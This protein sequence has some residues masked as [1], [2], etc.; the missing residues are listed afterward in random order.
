M[1]E[2]MEIGHKSVQWIDDPRL[3]DRSFL[4]E[5]PLI[6]EK[7]H[8]ANVDFLMGNAVDKLFEC[9]VPGPFAHFAPYPEYRNSIKRLF[10]RKVLA[11]FDPDFTRETLDNFF[12]GDGEEHEE[13]GAK[14]YEM[15]EELTNLNV[16]LEEIYHKI[17]SCLKP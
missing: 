6:P 12:E 7:M 5:V 8:I 13:E 1:T 14:L 9:S 10:K 11:T 17:F 16:I 4:D 3:I 2:V 15:L